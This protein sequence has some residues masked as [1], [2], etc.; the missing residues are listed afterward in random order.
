MENVPN[1]IAFPTRTPIRTLIAQ[2]QALVDGG[3]LTQSQA[4]GLLDKL[5]QV[6]TKL[7]HGQTNAVCNQL[8]SFITQVSALANNGSLTQSQ[9]QPLISAANAI[10]SSSGCQ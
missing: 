10:R 4:A 3:A 9:A 8:S 6:A 1:L 5:N 7:A 2:V